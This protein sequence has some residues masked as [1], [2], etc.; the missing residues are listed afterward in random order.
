MIQRVTGQLTGAAPG[1]GKKTQNAPKAQ[2]GFGAILQ[3]EL[4]KKTAGPRRNF[5]KTR[6]IPGGRA[7]H[8]GDAALDGPAGGQRGPGPGQGGR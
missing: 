2:A 8:P 6:H 5:F 4:A 3:Q 7:G 1:Q